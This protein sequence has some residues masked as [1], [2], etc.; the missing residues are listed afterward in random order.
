M[1]E[2]TIEEIAVAREMLRKDPRAGRGSLSTLLGCTPYRAMSILDEVKAEG[3]VEVIEDDEG[4]KTWDAKGE[5]AVASTRLPQ[6]TSLDQ[7]LQEFNVDREI[8]RVDRHVINQWGK[9]DMLQVKAWLSRR[10]T[11][12]EEEV[13]RSLIERSV[14][15]LPAKPAMLEEPSLDGHMLILS[16][17]DHHFGKLAWAKETGDN[18]D[19]KLA[20]QLY[21]W[22]IEDALA[23]VGDRP[24]DEI[25]IPV[26][27][28]LFHF[29]SSRGTTANGTQMDVDSRPAKVF[30]SACFAVAA[31]IA[32]ASQEAPVTVHFIP[33]N[34]DPTW[35]HHLCVFL[36]A[37]FRNND[38]V[39][40][41][42]N[43]MGR[44]Y[45]EYG[46]N[47]ILMTHGDMSAQNIRNLPTQMAVMVPEAWGRTRH[48]EVHLG[49]FHNQKEIAFVPLQEQSGVMLRILPSLC[50][51]DEW[52]FTKGFV[53]N[54]RAMVSLLYSKTRGY[55]GQFISYA[56]DVT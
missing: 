30:V 23:Q 17:V 42:F 43:P 4:G 1:S 34:H 54:K 48:W 46:T 33:G 55:S 39:K 26:G 3:K 14:T 12:M 19:L 52:H 10:V 53:G 16:P 2:V 36:W 8:W 49:H 29:D 20:E 11:V 45:V 56:K 21:V 15:P 7:L 25:H 22:A 40:V 38:N 44:K 37:Y 31:G 27:H 18:Y 28:D 13:I 32:R 9:G 41:D 47:L 51:T 6:I 5:T 35:S 50:G 24:L